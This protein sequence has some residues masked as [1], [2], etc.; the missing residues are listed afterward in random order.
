MGVKLRFLL[1]LGGHSKQAR[2]ERDLPHDVPFF[3][4][5]IFPFLTMFI[6]SYPWSVFHAV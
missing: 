3:H 2:D 5:R 6:T 1:S 4:A